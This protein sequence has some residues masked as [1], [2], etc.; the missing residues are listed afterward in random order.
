MEAVGFE[1]DVTAL[2][3]KANLLII[4]RHSFSLNCRHVILHHYSPHKLAI[5]AELEYRVNS[6]LV[7]RLLPKL[8]T[9]VHP[10][11]QNYVRWWRGEEVRNASNDVGQ[12]DTISLL[13]LILPFY[14]IYSNNN[15]MLWIIS[16]W[17]PDAHL[18]S[19]RKYDVCNV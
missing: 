14:C 6:S 16:G 1:A 12:Q 9:Y 17:L 11:V 13:Y 10:S 18:S 19:R 7:M 3:T 4:S 2:R 5:W 8:S 15:H